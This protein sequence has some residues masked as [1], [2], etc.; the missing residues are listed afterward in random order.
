MSIFDTII[1]DFFFF[2]FFGFIKE[3]L[4]YVYFSDML[5]LTITEM[6]TAG[7]DSPFM[8]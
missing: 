5:L 6:D 7:V 2:F 1:G 3:C 4:A 8:L